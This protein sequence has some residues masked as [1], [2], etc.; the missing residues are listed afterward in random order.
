MADLTEIV[1]TQKSPK[2]IQLCI[3]LV[4]QRLMT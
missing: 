4:S 2:S 1:A 3:L